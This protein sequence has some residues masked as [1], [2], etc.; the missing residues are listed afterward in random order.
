MSKPKSKGSRKD[1]AGIAATKKKWD[2]LV[3]LVG[4]IYEAKK[5]LEEAERELDELFPTPEPG[6]G[7]NG[8]KTS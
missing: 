2:T 5:A 1:N 4:R 8:R 6:A 3:E 7:K